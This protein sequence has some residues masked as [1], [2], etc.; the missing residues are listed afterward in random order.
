MSARAGL[1]NYFSNRP[2]AIKMIP[3]PEAADLISAP[4]GQ[5][6]L[7]STGTSVIDSYLIVD[8]REH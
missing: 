5:T 3:H 4:A 2:D 1:Q 6:Y 7:T 8:I